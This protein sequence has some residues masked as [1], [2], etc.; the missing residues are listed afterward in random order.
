MT[1]GANAAA[2]LEQATALVHHAA[3]RG[4]TYIQLPEYAAFWGPERLLRGGAQT[5]DG[6]FITA[7][8]TIARERDVTVH[9]GSFLEQGDGVLRNTSVVLHPSGQRAVY[10]KLHLFDV[11]IPDGIVYRESAL[12]TPGHEMIVNVAASLTLG[13]TI[14]FDLRFPELYRAL[15]VAGANVLCVP[16]AF[17]A[18]TGPAHWDVLL[19]ARAIENGAFVLAAAQAGTTPEGVS[20]HGHALI[21]DPWGTALAESSTDGPEV[22]VATIDLDVV[23]DRRRHINTLALRRPALY[24]GVVTRV[25]DQAVEPR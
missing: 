23:E 9:V 5:L 17:S 7:M 12:I 25:V 14:C 19:R 24:N 16:S 10:R 4:A 13:L 15:S 18:V 1:T 22:L 11:E 2:N 20:T 8:A 3:D 6:P 21:V